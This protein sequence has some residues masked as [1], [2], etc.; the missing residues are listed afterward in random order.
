MIAR[1]LYGVVVWAPGRL[2][3]L[4][5]CFVEN[6]RHR[7]HENWR[8]AVE[9]DVV[10]DELLLCKKRRQQGDYNDAK[11]RTERTRTAPPST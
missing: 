10:S 4:F 5:K 2:R 7:Q 3:V 9:K 11:R 8:S 6:H 1:V